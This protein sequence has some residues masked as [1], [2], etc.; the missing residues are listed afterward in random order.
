[1]NMN[2]LDRI[3]VLGTRGIPANYSG[4]ETCVQETSII[5]ADQG[6]HV[7]VYCRKSRVGESTILNNRI[8]CVFVPYF[9]GKHLE[10]IS[11]TFFSTVHLLFNRIEYVHLYGVGNGWFAPLLRLFGFRV[12]FMMDGLDWHRG[13]WSLLAKWFLKNG[14]RV[15]SYFSNTSSADSNHVIEALNAAFARQKFVYI[16]YGAK[17]VTAAPGSKLKELGLSK[18]NYFLFVGRFVPEKNIG[19]LVS[20]F[21]KA[22]TR[23]FLVVVGGGSYSTE[24]E[25]RVMATS[26]S[27][28]LFPGFVYGAAY[29][30]LISNCYT[31]IQPSALEGTSPSLLGSMGAGAS[32][33]VSD[34]PENQETVGD[35]GFYFRNNDEKDLVRMI[36]YI[37]ENSDAVSEKRREALSRV[38]E[39]YSWKKVTQTLLDVTRSDS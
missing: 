23:R 19:L 6:Y 32:V 27:R 30:E 34:I 33:L 31:Y 14:A 24:Y 2:N 25:R 4:F 17:I 28:I 7:R 15:G 39:V 38:K 16:P 9:T 10:T 22:K 1:M 26:C 37:D 20:A 21:E 18:Y 3:A 12:V 5:M 13:K 36:E 11:H 29:E 35:A 8:E